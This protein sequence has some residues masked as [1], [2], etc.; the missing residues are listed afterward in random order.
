M[1]RPNEESRKIVDQFLK[2][3]GEPLLP[4]QPERAAEEVWARLGLA[5]GNVADPV[6][7]FSPRV[8]RRPW[9]FVAAAALTASLAVT[10]YIVIAGLLGSPS[11]ASAAS[12]EL[13]SVET[14]KALPA[15]DRI[16]GGQDIRAGAQGGAIALRDGSRIELSPGAALSIIP[17]EDGPNVRLDSGTLIVTA[18]KQ[19][20]GE[21]LHV[22]TKDFRVS[23]LGTLFT[24]SAEE[25]GSR[26]SVI[27]GEVRVRRGEI[28]EILAPGQQVST[29]L[30]LGPVPVKTQIE[31][32]PQAMKL[33]ALLP[34]PPRLQTPAPQNSLGVVRGTVTQQS[35]GEG[36][37]G[38]AVTLCASGAVSPGGHTDVGDAGVAGYRVFIYALPGVGACVNPVNVT[39]D[40]R[41]R[42]EFKDVAAGTYRVRAQREGYFSPPG[43]RAT[44]GAQ[45]GYLIR[46]YSQFDPQTGAPAANGAEP[47]LRLWTI[48]GARQI[49]NS[50]SAVEQTVTIGAANP[51]VDLALNLIR[52]AAI[53]GRLRD[54]EGKPLSNVPVSVLA[55]AEEASS[56]ENARS[57][58]AGVIRRRTGIT[59]PLEFT[60]VAP[61]AYTLF[62]APVGAPSFRTTDDRGEF[63]LFGIPPGEYYIVVEPPAPLAQSSSSASAARAGGAVAPSVSRPAQLFYPGVTVPGDA[64]R[65][66]LKEGDDLS[67]FDIVVPA[68]SGQ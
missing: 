24:V 35:N 60:D 53:S 61:G 40:N 5:T 8:A 16:E 9:R 38:V 56:L 41:G 57:A 11:I 34:E 52:G 13:Y 1:K 6:R 66:I 43:Q 49:D 39:T 51:S 23:V 65:V 54:A 14:G 29:S 47:Y 44:P 25:R 19:Q 4:G 37:P 64:R 32:S 68:A 18:A 46:R 12:G 17:V 2:E 58:V 63:R 15:A 30:A 36:I 62:T 7:L 45:Q 22:T 67:G 31:W 27:E 50:A 26:V 3:L 42:F 28:S 55:A 10:A 33:V 59:S 20:S 48:N 21:H